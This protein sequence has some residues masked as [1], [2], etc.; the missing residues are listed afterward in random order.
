VDVTF[1]KITKDDFIECAN[2][3]VAA[4]SGEP[5]NNSWTIQEALLRVESTMSGSNSK[6]YIAESSGEIIAMC[7][8]RIDYY[9][10]GWKQYCVDEFNVLPTLQGKGVGSGLQDYI[11][12]LM[13]EDGVAR[14]FLV[15]GGEMAA[16]F[17][18]KNGYEK[19]DDGI[20][21]TLDLL[22]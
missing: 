14:L 9:Y 21:L 7:L 8:G 10:G 16:K 13:K 6:G 20:M 1:R 2:V 15:T 11:S 19:S 17:Y 3:L 4:Y 5:W 12:R 18:V 22:K